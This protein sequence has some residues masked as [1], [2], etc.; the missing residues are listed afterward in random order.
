MFWPGPVNLF[1]QFRLKA[2]DTP[3]ELHQRLAREEQYQAVRNI[4]LYVSDQKFF[5]TI[6]RG[7]GSI[8][9]YVKGSKTD[10]FQTTGPK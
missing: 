8:Y 1:L 5:C 3:I 6:L 10:L 9:T 2:S 7:T 4:P